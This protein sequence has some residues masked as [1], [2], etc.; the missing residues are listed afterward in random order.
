MADTKTGERR[1]SIVES[2]NN[3]GDVSKTDSPEETT[4]ALNV[5]YVIVLF[6]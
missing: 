4:V 3:I 1:Y 2:A 5:F 6:Y